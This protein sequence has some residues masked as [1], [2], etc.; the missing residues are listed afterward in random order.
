MHEVRADWERMY[1]EVREKLFPA[2]R[3]DARRDVTALFESYLD[4]S[5]LHAFT[6]TL[7]H[8]DFGGDNIL[9]DPQAGRITAIIDFSFCALGD[10]A[11][12]LAS[13]STMGNEFFNR[14][15][16]RYEPDEA[17]R[18][19]VLARARFYRGTFALSEAL[20]GLRLSDPEAYRRG[21]EEYV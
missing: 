13:A 9:W 21:M 10:P 16:P 11:Y 3:L 14:L 5:A 6:P 17:R 12:D 2:M 15:A 8:G 18:A 4:D 20:D 7:R 19:P 1:A